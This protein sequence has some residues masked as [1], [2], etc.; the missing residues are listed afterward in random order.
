MMLPVTSSERRVEFSMIGKVGCYSGKKHYF[1]CDLLRNR[2]LLTL[3]QP[4]SKSYICK[5]PEVFVT[6]PSVEKIKRLTGKMEINLLSCCTQP[7]GNGFYF[8]ILVW[9]ERER[10]RWKALRCGNDNSMRFPTT[11]FLLASNPPLPRY[12]LIH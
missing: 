8:S 3:I 9:W 12:L 7:S 1:F 4:L 11:S 10:E 6:L 2:H 5:H